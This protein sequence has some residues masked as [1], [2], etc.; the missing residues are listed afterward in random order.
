M[1]SRLSIRKFEKN[2]SD[3]SF[4]F[5]IPRLN[6]NTGEEKTS[7]LT[8]FGINQ[9]RG[10]MSHV[11]SAIHSFK[12]KYSSNAVYPINIICEPKLASAESA[13]HI[14]DLL[15]NANY[16]VAPQTTDLGLLFNYYDKS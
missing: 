1:I 11:H 13:F 16:N 4:F 14:R 9:I 2:F 6:V 5:Y 12:K 7:Y 3:F 10:I 15:L 8:R